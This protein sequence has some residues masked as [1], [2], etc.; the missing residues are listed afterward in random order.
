MSGGIE[1]DDSAIIDVEYLTQLYKNKFHKDVDYTIV[2]KGLTQEKLV[3]CLDYML[4][5]NVSL[6]VAYEYLFG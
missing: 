6:V 4:E 2:P 3:D 1:I 5:T